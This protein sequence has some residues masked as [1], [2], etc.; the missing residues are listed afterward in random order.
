MGWIPEPP[1][2]S[3]LVN[4]KPGAERSW[5]LSCQQSAHLE[6]HKAFLRAPQLG[7]G[8]FHPTLMNSDPLIHICLGVSSV[9]RKSAALLWGVGWG[10]PGL[11]IPGAL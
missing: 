1:P 5:P 2:R 6:S 7:P 11:G 3:Q 10:G 8:L 9:Q 4:M